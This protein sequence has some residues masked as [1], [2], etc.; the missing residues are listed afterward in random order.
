MRPFVGV[1]GTHPANASSYFSDLPRMRFKCLV[2]R[3]A[4]PVQLRFTILLTVARSCAAES[5]N[6]P[7][8]KPR[9]AACV[10]GAT[11]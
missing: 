8:V 10:R 9:R 2:D 7:S 5:Q 11:G 1:C 6:A 4:L 3:S